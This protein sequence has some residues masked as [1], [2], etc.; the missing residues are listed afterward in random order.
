LLLSVPA[1]FDS[2]VLSGLGLPLLFCFGFTVLI[3]SVFVSVLLR[4]FVS[5]KANYQKHN[6]SNI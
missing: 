3:L 4:I 6:I 5:V 1:S 2:L